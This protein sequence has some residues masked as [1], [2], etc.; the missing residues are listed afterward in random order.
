MLRGELQGRT[1]ALVLEGAALHRQEL[2]SDWERARRG[3]LLA[4]IAPLE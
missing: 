2:K 4:P 3:E 1:L